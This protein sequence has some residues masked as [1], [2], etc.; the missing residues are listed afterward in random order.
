MY[1]SFGKGRSSKSRVMKAVNKLTSYEKS[2][3]SVNI[4][5]E[6]RNK[7]IDGEKKTVFCCRNYGGYPGEQAL[8]K[9]FTDKVKF[10]EYITSMIDGFDKQL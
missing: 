4:N 3:Q 5:I 1:E 8:P 6:I 7:I 2:E 10:K 9:E